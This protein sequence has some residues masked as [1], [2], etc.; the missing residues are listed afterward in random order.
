MKGFVVIVYSADQR[1]QV[2]SVVNVK[3]VSKFLARLIAERAL[4]KMGEPKRLVW[5]LL[6]FSIKCV[7][8]QKYARSIKWQ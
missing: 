4:F 3:V 1:A 7:Y 5:Q 6:C 2:Y 8:S